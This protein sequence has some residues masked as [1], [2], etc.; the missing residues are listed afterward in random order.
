M[1]CFLSRGYAPVLRLSADGKLAT[2]FTQSV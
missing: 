2:A 1:R